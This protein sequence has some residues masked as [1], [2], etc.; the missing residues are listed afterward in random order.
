M[1]SFDVESLFNN[2]PLEE[3]IDLAVNY[4]S[5]GNP[6]I[7]LI[8]NWFIRQR[9]FIEIWS[10]WEV[11]RARKMRKSCSRL[12]LEQLKLLVFFLEGFVADVMSVDNRNMK[13]AR[14]IEFDYTNLLAML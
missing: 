8:N 11:W 7:K 6:E 4:V 10:T 1:V 14:A 2:I 3:C 12:R 5:E 9:A 13:H